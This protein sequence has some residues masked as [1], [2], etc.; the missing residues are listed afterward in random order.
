MTDVT[1]SETR[2]AP[3]APSMFIR[4]QIGQGGEERVA[5]LVRLLDLQEQQP[6]V[7]R[8]RDWVLTV[9]APG[10]GD[11]AVDVGS[12]TGTEVIRLAEAVAPNG[13][14]V[15][16]EPNPALRAE[17]ERRAAA[18]A[19]TATFV[20]GDAA[21]LPFDDGSVHVLRCERV[22]QHL[23]DPLA[24]AREIAR[25]LAPGGRAAVVDSDWGTVVTHPGD[26][27]VLRR[28]AASTWSRMPNPF[29]GRL[30]R[31]QLRRA[32]LV[33]DDD[34][35]SSA[36]VMPADQLL[37]SGMMHVNAAAA[38][39]DGHLTREEADGLLASIEAGIDDGSAFVAVT[40]FAVVGRRPA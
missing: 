12:G 11:S 1:G 3:T 2:T 10:L 38:V 13:R 21:D 39:A 26:P 8:L 17:A 33:V 25:V 14:A 40:M 27:D 4:S 35:G 28:Y 24:A 32:G 22:F 34:I 30:L 7:T 37:A 29:S 9:L 23:D 31:H 15:G 16:V 5:A 18:A 6:A 36:L 19:S 20:D